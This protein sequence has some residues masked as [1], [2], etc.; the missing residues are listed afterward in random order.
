MTGGQPGAG[1]WG[2]TT[3]H[4]AGSLRAAF[5][6]LGACFERE[7]RRPLTLCFGAAGLLRDRLQAGEPSSLFAS[8]N[9]DHPQALVSTGRAHTVSPFA[10][11]RLCLLV[12]P[13][14]DLRGQGLASRLLDAD[15]RIGTSTPGA[16]PSGDYAWQLFDHIE[17]SGSAP[18]GS[19][20][21]LKTRA[22]Q[23][24][25]RGEK[26]EE[27]DGRSR[28][29]SL[30]Q[31]GQADVFITYR[32]NAVRACADFPALRLLDL[33]DALAVDVRYGLVVLE[34]EPA[35]GAA[36]AAML[37]GSPGQAVL[38]DHGFSSPG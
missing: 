2:M 5:T 6:V 34:P 20:A 31:A 3:V 15:V 29:G 27:G 19:A 33:P 13:G 22:L 26:T 25:G 18:A 10:R 21:V 14:F 24:T 8:A 12:A 35:G 28:Y 37:L 7:F 30:L 1:P 4:A 38:R 11:N 32:S 9:L 16:D 23:L 17:A 36:F